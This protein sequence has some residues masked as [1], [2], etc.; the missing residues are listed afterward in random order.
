M[1]FTHASLM[2]NTG[3]QK[4]M[5]TKNEKI[6]STEGSTTGAL[7]VP[8][9]QPFDLEF[10]WIDNLNRPDDIMDFYTCGDAAP[11]ERFNYQYKGK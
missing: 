9:G 3:L 6:S 2:L 10:K 7:N 8:D 4:K 5:C 1:S 11:G